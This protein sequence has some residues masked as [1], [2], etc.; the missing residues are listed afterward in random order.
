VLERRVPL[1]SFANGH[2]ESLRVI[3]HRDQFV[4]VTREFRELPPAL[5]VYLSWTA[6]SFDAAGS[7]EG[8]A[9][10]P[11]TVLADDESGVE[12]LSAASS[13]SA[14]L[15]VYD[16][17]SPPEEGNVSRVYARLFGGYG[18]RRRAIR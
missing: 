3:A 17:I 10:L 8:V 1:A 4:L 18:G 5:A 9:A 14:M 13:G 15:V 11:R 7:L 12:T 2:V 6:V 16:R